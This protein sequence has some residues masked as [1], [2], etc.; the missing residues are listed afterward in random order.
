MIFISNVIIVREYNTTTHKIYYD[1]N[2]ILNKNLDIIFFKNKI[3]KSRMFYSFLLITTLR[4]H[5][6]K[7]LF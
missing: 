3:N 6:V 1:G 2:E 7:Y 5:L 4:V